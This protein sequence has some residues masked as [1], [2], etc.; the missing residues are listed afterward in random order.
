[1]SNTLKRRLLKG[2]ALTVDVLPPFIAT[3]AQFPIWIEKSADATLSG[4]FIVLAFLSCIPFLKQIKAFIK[5]P[6]VPILWLVM[7]VFLTALSNII[8][9]MIVVCFVGAI[10][11]AVGAIIYKLGD[12]I[13]REDK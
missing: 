10:S 11:N 3:I 12:S 5:S 8:S 13:D 1:M 7:F 2:T 4:V 9:Q 6:S